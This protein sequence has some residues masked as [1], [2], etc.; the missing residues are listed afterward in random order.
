MSFVSTL[1]SLRRHHLSVNRA[2]AVASATKFR[3]ELV[4]AAT[5]RAGNPPRL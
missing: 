1:R 3:D 4:H 2:V 5:V